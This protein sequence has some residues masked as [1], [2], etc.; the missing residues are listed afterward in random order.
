[1]KM[2]ELRTQV[3]RIITWGKNKLREGIQEGNSESAVEI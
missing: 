1:M 2:A 3:C